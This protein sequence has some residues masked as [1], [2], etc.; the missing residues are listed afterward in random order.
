MLGRSSMSR[1]TSLKDK[2]NDFRRTAP[3]RH[4][5]KIIISLSIIRYII[6]NR[7]KSVNW[8]RGHV[9]DDYEYKPQRA[10]WLFSRSAPCGV[11]RYIRF[12]R[13]ARNKPVLRMRRIGT[14]LGIGSRYAAFPGNRSISSCCGHGGA[15]LFGF[16]GH[17]GRADR[18]CGPP[19]RGGGRTN[20]A[21]CTT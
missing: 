13:T 9:M 19:D 8:V 20:A 4:L 2:A 18:W 5:Q 10:D 7:M 16:Y 21:P 11:A 6:L 1:L 14:R 17:S 12:E 3:L 15:R